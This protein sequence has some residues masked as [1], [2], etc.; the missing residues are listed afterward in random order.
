LATYLHLLRAD[1]SPVALPLIAEQAGQEPGGVVVV[2]TDDA[3]APALPAGVALHRLG[4]GDLDHDA[5]LDLIFASDHVIA[6]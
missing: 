6:W 4:H 1:S 5:L 3:P 2:Q